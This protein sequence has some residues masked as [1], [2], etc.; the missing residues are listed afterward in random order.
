MEKQSEP[1]YTPRANATKRGMP[2]KLKIAVLSLIIVAIVGAALPLTGFF[3][4]LSPPPK[5]EKYYGAISEALKENGAILPKERPDYLPAEVY[6]NLPPFPEDFYYID[7]IVTFQEGILDLE[8]LE[9]KYYK[10]PEFY[11][12]WES[13]GVDLTR[14]PE[15]GRATLWGWGAYPADEGFSTY[16]GQEFTA[17]TFFHSSWQVQS[18]Q[19]MKLETVFPSTSMVRGSQIHSADAEKYFTAVISPDLILLGPTFPRFDQNWT[20]KVSV[21]I[22]VSPEAPPGEYLIGVNPT[23]PP[24]EVKREWTLQ[25]KL[26][27]VDGGATGFDRPYF[28]MLVQV[29]PLPS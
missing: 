4:Y 21:K 23:F 27:Y 24:T 13:M 3:T 12:T 19:G 20:Y 1:G 18:W 6:E 25:H 5:E 28:Q 29:N 17:A 26:R 15:R 7:E 10:Q 8:N 11:P 22:K 14:N 9:D 2:R 16:P